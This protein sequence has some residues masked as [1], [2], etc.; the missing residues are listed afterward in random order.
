MSASANTRTGPR[1]IAT[2]WVPIVWPLSSSSATAF[3]I[4]R[5]RRLGAGPSRSTLAPGSVRSRRAGNLAEQRRTRRRQ[6]L[7]EARRRRLAG[8]REDVLAARAVGGAIYVRGASGDPFG[9]GERPTAHRLVVGDEGPHLVDRGHVGR[10][11]PPVEREVVG[12][13]ADHDRFGGGADAVPVEDGD[14]ASG[15]HGDV[16]GSPVEVA[17]DGRGARRGFE[18]GAGARGVGGGAG[19]RADLLDPLRADGGGRKVERRTGRRG[20]RGPRGR[21]PQGA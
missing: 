9:V 2:F 17:D 20:E 8:R 4:G 3:S 6:P 12:R 5:S 7:P 13:R 16:L 14:H 19:A 1:S 10:R 18:V 11:R 21:W 15:G